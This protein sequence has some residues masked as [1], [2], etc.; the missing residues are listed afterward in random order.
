[1]TKVRFY[2]WEQRLKNLEDELQ[3]FKDKYDAN[4]SN[5]NAHDYNK[6]LPKVNQV[7]VRHGLK[8]L[9]EIEKTFNNPDWCSND[10]NED[11]MILMNKIIKFHT[12]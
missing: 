8:E 9:P 3:V 2:T 11:P 7:R 1:M 12:S 6:C 5:Y 10:Y 4:P